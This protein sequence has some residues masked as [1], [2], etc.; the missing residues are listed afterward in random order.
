MI[1]SL[2]RLAAEQQRRF[3]AT[4]SHRARKKRGHF[5]TTPA[6]ADFMAWMFTKSQYGSSTLEREWARYRLLCAR[7]FCNSE[8]AIISQIRN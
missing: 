7:G 4:T 8:I 3:D 2:T 1:E 5:G 6:I